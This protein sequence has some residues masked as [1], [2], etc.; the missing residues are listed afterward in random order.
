MA[1]FSKKKHDTATGKGVGVIPTEPELYRVPTH[2]EL[3]QKLRDIEEV[4]RRI[5]ADPG[6]QALMRDMFGTEPAA[7]P[8]APPASMEEVRAHLRTGGISYLASP[9]A[10][11]STVVP[12][13]DE[14]WADAI[15]ASMMGDDAGCLAAYEKALAVTRQAGHRTGEARLL[16]N[17]GLAHYKL[18]HLDRAIEVLLEGRALTESIA[19]ELGREARKLQRFET[20]VK[21]DNPRIEVTGVPQIEQWLLEKYL[22]ALAIVYDADS[23]AAQAAACRDE[24]KRLHP[25]G[26]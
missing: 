1:W 12:E 22:E 7:R 17:I 2:E 10:D 8:A 14:L 13:A 9:P 15:V 11:T 18:G 21:T 6:M 23:Q 5:D 19:A 26:M 25:Q 24:I 16:Y 3:E 4:N 20:E